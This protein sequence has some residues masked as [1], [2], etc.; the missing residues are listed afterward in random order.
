[1][2]PV[3]RQL[4]WFGGLWAGSVAAV[5]GIAFVLRAWIGG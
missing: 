2:P 5:G 4:A 3:L 1:M